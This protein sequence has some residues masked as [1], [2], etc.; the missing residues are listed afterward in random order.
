MTKR[1]VA[2][3]AALSAMLNDHFMDYATLAE[4]D[5]T[6]DRERCYFGEF[7]R[8]DERWQFLHKDESLANRANQACLAAAGVTPKT[9][10]EDVWAQILEAG[11]DPTKCARE[12]SP[13]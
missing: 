2:V 8:V 4:A 11:L 1:H 12:Y 3:V 9:T 7:Q 13:E 6:G 10:T 5:F